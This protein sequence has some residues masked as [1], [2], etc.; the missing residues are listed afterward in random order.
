MQQHSPYRV[1]LNDIDVARTC[2]NAAD[3]FQPTFSSAA[4][5][6]SES[7]CAS[8][9]SVQSCV[10]R[11]CYWGNTQAAL[12]ALDATELHGTTILLSDRETV[13]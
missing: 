1:V 6:L 10:R 4:R 3:Y 7:V 11:K 8:G 13:H 12:E 9:A 5:H 2:F